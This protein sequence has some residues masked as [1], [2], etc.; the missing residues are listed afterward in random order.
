MGLHNFNSEDTMFDSIKSLEEQPLCVGSNCSFENQFLRHRKYIN[1]LY[2]KYINL[3]TH[4]HTMPN[5]RTFLSQVEIFR[6]S[7][8]I[9]FTYVDEEFFDYGV[10][11]EILNLFFRFRDTDP[12]KIKTHF[13]YSDFEYKY[14]RIR[15]SG[16][17]RYKILFLQE[18]LLRLYVREFRENGSHY[19]PR[20]IR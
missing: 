17:N 18:E 1:S 8:A 4:K 11:D 9:D 19:V 10:Y 20:G 6:D 15:I 7:L 5:K 12:S 16:L 3:A 2:K 13:R 14:T